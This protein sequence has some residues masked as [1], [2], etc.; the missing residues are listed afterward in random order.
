MELNGRMK[1]F[2]KKVKMSHADSGTK[3]T[4]VMIKLCRI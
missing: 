3:N 2:L 1:H 4:N